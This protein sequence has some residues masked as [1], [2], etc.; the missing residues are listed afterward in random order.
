MQNSGINGAN[1]SIRISLG[2]TSTYITWQ[3]NFLRMDHPRKL[4]F[5]L[6]VT[7][8]LNDANG[9]CIGAWCA[10][11]TIGL[12]AGAAIVAAADG[13]AALTSYDAVQTTW[14]INGSTQGLTGGV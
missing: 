7:S 4:V 9:L 6:G 11:D 3:A 14:R 1:V 2:D 8:G 10:D 5:D 13:V 12:S